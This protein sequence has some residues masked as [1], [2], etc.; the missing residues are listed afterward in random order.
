MMPQNRFHVVDKRTGE[1][2]KT[3]YYSEP[4][5]FFHFVNSYEEEDHLIIDVDAYPSHK[6]MDKMSIERLRA[7]DLDQKDPSRIQRFVLPIIRNVKVRDENF[8][9]PLLG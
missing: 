9:V 1:V 7:G 3:K 8:P 6:V 2:F 4:F 5:F